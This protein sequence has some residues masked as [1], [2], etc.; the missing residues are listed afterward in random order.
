MLRRVR[1]AILCLPRQV[2][3]Q[4]PVRMHLLWA[5]PTMI[6]PLVMR[7]TAG[8]GLWLSLTLR[9]CPGLILLQRHSCPLI[10]GQAPSTHILTQL[11]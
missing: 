3:T 8:S 11:L 4:F 2:R 6:G 10:E 1:R 5:L 7:T 9:L